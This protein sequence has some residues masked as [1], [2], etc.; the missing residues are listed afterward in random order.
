M[1]PREALMA[2]EGTETE[3]QQRGHSTWVSLHKQ[4]FSRQTNGT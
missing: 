1:E 4:E 2:G 3:A